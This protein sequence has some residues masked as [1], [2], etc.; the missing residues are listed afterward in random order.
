ML[1]IWISG[2]VLLLSG[3]V[4]AQTEEKVDSSTEKSTEKPRFKQYD[5]VITAEAVSS[6][7][8]L[9]VHQIRDKVYFEL[10]ID[11]LEDELLIVSRISGFVKG[12]N[13]GGAGMKSRPQQVIRFQRHYDQIL[14]RSVSYNS[15]ASEEDPVYRSVRNNN[16]EPVIS[17][18]DIAC[19][20]SDSTA[21]VI[22]VTSFFTKDVPMI[23]ALSEE[24][25][26]EFQ[27]SSLDSKRSFVSSAKAFPENVEIRHVLTYAGKKLPDNLLTGTLSIEMNQSIIRLPHQ[28]WP[29]RYFDKRVAYFSLQQADYGVNEQRAAKRQYITR[30]RLEPSD[31]EAYFRG[32]LVEPLKPIIYYV[33]PAT[34]TKWVP[35]L[36]AGINDWQKAFEAAGFK[37]AIQGREAPVDDPDW[38]PEDVRY[39]VIRY[40]TTDIQNAQ[41][42]HVH[43][44][45]TGEILESDI[46]WYHNVMNL[47]RNWYYIQTAA[48]NPEAQSP[49]YSDEI[50]G[51][52]IRF[53]ASHEVGHT[54][55]LPHNMGASSAYPVDSLRSPTFTC[56]MGTAPSIMDYARYNYIAQPEDSGVCLSPQIG[57]YDLWSIEY[58]YRLIPKVSTPDDERPI[59]RQWIKAHAND[60]VY[61]FGRQTGDPYDPSAQTEDLGDDAMKASLYGIANLKRIRTNLMTW[62]NRPGEDYSDLDE[63]YDQVFVQMGR[64]VRHVATQIGGVY[65]YS[66]NNDQAGAVFTPVSYAHQEKAMKFLHQEVFQTPYWMIDTL[67][68]RR[69]EITG[70]HDRIL[71]LQKSALSILLKESRLERLQTNPIISEGPTYDMDAL[72]QSLTNGLFSEWNSGK[73]PD[74]FRRNLQREYVLQLGE[75]IK[76]KSQKTDASAQA[77]HQLIQIRQLAQRTAKRGKGIDKAHAQDLIAHGNKLLKGDSD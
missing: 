19:F 33:D 53:V 76:R 41:G 63:L 17:S 4:F 23:G 8:L 7:G 16:F 43:D 57:P 5:K 68:L 12:L 52:L 69:I 26:K 55:G 18:F 15:V 71:R 11:L 9:S 51:Q 24:Q 13:F 45:R 6:A 64:Y 28:K 61:R 67:I 10:P 32:E 39:S 37:N 65:E 49:Q 75:I 66:K 35:Y 73:Q 36:M 48:V 20:N 47:L 31:P 46:L 38:S 22:D 25:R 1:K 34:P 27:I 21:L 14:L 60:P 56:A 42:P 77:R 72:F 62:G 3:V 44:P 29:A 58:G 70:V 30:W 40:I 59:L 50:M 74:N 54:L 2:I